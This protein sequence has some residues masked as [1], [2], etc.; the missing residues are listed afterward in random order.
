MNE[1]DRKFLSHIL[2]GDTDALGQRAIVTEHGLQLSFR[3]LGQ[4][5]NLL[6]ETLKTAGIQSHHRVSTILPNG[7]ACSL[8]MLAVMDTAIACPLASTCTQDEYRNQLSALEADVLICSAAQADDFEAICTD[9]GMTLLAIDVNIESPAVEVGSSTVGRTASPSA[10]ANRS[11]GASASQPVLILLTSGSTGKPKRVALTASNLLY[12]ANEVA[13]SL[14]L[15]KQDLC[16]SMWEQYHIGGVVDVLLAPLLAGSSILMTSGFSLANLRDGFKHS[17]V[18]WLQCVP[19]T[20]REIIRCT[21]REK[22]SLPP[23]LRF[24]RSVASQLPIS[25]HNEAEFI[26]GVPILQTYGMTEAS[27]LITSNRL[28]VGAKK[29]GTVGKPLSTEF[30][31]ISPDESTSQTVSGAGEGEILIRG[32]NVITSYDDPTAET[33]SCF[34]DGWF[35]TGDTGYFD[36]DGFLVLTGRVKQMINRGGEKISPL[37]IESAAIGLCG[38]ERAL[39]FS[40]PHQTL[41][42]VVGLIVCGEE[43]SQSSD[44]SSLR[45]QLAARLSPFKLP[46]RI[47]GVEN[48]PH[49]TTGKL[50]Q[51]K[52]NEIISQ[53]PVAGVNIPKTYPKISDEAS[54]DSDK[55]HQYLQYLWKDEI[56]VGTVGL[57]DEFEELGGDSLS[58]VRILA[59]LE[60]DLNLHITLASVVGLTTV[61]KLA[62]YLR[63]RRI[64]ISF[65]SLISRETPSSLESSRDD[66]L[67]CDTN[68]LEGRILSSQTAVEFLRNK[69]LCL[70]RLTLQEIITLI[71]SL[72][73]HYG[74]MPQ[75]EWSEIFRNELLKWQQE[76]FKER[77]VFPEGLHWKRKQI[78]LNAQLYQCKA[79]G[80]ETTTLIV[81]VTGNQMRLMLPVNTILSR[82]NGS[83]YDLLLIQDP[84]RSHYTRG[85]RGIANSLHGLAQWLNQ[86]TTS[87][88][89]KDVI[90]FGTSAGA[91]AAI[92][93]G[94]TNGWKRSIGVGA[95]KPSV[96]GQ[97]SDYIVYLSGNLTETNEASCTLLFDAKN[98]RDKEGALEIKD[99]LKGVKLLTV[100]AGGEHNLLHVARQ[101]GKLKKT[102]EL[103]LEH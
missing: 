95:E 41:G 72:E 43:I 54:S 98:Q 61:R 57:D 38:V 102:L 94:L 16:L 71:E 93:I 31:F 78:S 87:A 36:E 97:L 55:L 99:H 92:L 7:T 40:I 96:N 81:G 58:S 22:I 27:P 26:L 80:K 47:W 28:E 100:H 69:E 83:K 60:V 37:E 76:I 88:G 66:D 30:M 34:K 24:I 90:A 46:A 17:D 64:D 70:N 63:T 29:A 67:E 8:I 32:I 75:D 68:E 14:G 59:Q 91:L 20:L 73:Q 45:E 4:L 48:I 53:L 52:A 84:T 82:I 62:A 56:D 33:S 49:T 103:I 39:A 44:M 23:N 6:T 42:S 21:K 89:Y 15:G 85:A 10:K 18:T 19:T 9:L 11:W 25:L 5:T 101:T 79:V 3:Q 86:Y 77:E 1:N 50:L 13:V 74:R 12:S 2:H 51:S 65:D 35:R